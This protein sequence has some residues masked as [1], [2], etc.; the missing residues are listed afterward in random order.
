M[1]RLPSTSVIHAPWP[2]AKK[3]GSPPTPRNARTGEFTPP[4]S[5]SLARAN[6][7]W[8]LDRFIARALA[9]A[10]V[11]PPP[12]YSGCAAGVAA[13]AVPV[14]GT[15]SAAAGAGATG[16]GFGAG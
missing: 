13:G 14:A 10:S 9:Q 2:L 8:L 6:T 3:T 1:Y 5:S 4:G 11:D 12:R 15:A 7:A 16:A